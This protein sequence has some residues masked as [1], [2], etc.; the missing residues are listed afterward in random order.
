M[1]DLGVPSRIFVNHRK[2]YPRAPFV[3]V[4]I[5]RLHCRL[6]MKIAGVHQFVIEENLKLDIMLV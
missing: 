6:D 3:F 4:V 2:L 1:N 5:R